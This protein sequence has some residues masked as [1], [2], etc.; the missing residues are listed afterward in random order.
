MNRTTKYESLQEL[1]IKHPRVKEA[2]YVVYKVNTNAS[3]KRDTQATANHDK[4]ILP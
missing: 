4:K 1:V 3:S 2:V